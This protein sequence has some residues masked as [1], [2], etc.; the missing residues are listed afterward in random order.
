MSDRIVYLVSKLTAKLRESRLEF[1]DDIGL[2]DLMAEGFEQV[3][4][5]ERKV[6]GAKAVM[7]TLRPSG[8]NRG[9][10]RVQPE[11]ASEVTI[12]DDFGNDRQVSIM[13]ALSNTNRELSQALQNLGGAGH[14]GSVKKHNMPGLSIISGE[15]V[16]KA[17]DLGQTANKRGQS[18]ED[19]PFPVGS[20]PSTQWLEGY[21]SLGQAQDV[22]LSAAEEAFGR[23]LHTARS[24]GKNDQVHCPYPMGSPLRGSWLNGFTE[25]GGRII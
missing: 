22:T 13:Q 19:N 1:V 12:S 20:G 5:M 25:G 3:A 8:E 24:L 2:S 14:L 7:V 11:R 9:L 17:Y 4:T 6:E 15:L 23:G 18:A 10:T 16:G 21:R